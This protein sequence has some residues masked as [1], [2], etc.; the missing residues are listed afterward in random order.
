MTKRKMFKIGLLVTAMG[1]VVVNSIHTNNKIKEVQE[2]VDIQQDMLYNKDTIIQDLNT[3]VKEQH[4]VINDLEWEKNHLVQ[5]IEERSKP[6]A[7]R[8]G[9]RVIDIEVTYYAPTGNLTASGTIPTAGRTCA[10]SSLP[11]GSHVIIDGHEYIV[12]DRTGVGGNVIDIFVD[13]EEEALSLGR[14]Y[15]TATI[16]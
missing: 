12:E 8:G 4:K 1:L 7:S 5:E 14:Q 6:Q 13:S 11:L 10:S 16:L 15:T 3:K 2:R 9:G